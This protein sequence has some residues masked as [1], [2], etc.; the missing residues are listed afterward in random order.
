MLLTILC[1]T[2]SAG[3]SQKQQEQQDLLSVLWLCEQCAGPLYTLFSDSRK[4]GSILL[5]SHPVAFNFSGS[6]Q[7]LWCKSIATSHFIFKR[8]LLC[9]EDVKFQWQSYMGEEKRA[10]QSDMEQNLLSSHSD[11]Y[12]VCR[13]QEGRYIIPVRYSIKGNQKQMLFF[14]AVKPTS[15]TC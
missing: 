5:K 8:P 7:I 3:E 1:I 14:S 11:T 4:T 9:S 12:A 10:H 15:R 2:P 6:A 13:K